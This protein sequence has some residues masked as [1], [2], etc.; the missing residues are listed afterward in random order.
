M[1]P[2]VRLSG[3]FGSRYGKGRRIGVG[4]TLHK[5]NRDLTFAGAPIRL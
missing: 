1:I 5:A 3:T 2:T 4:R